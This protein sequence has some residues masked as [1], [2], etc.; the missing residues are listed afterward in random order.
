MGSISR[1]SRESQ[2]NLLNNYRV[3]ASFCGKDPTSVAN[4]SNWIECYNPSNNSWHRVTS[5]PGLMQNQVLKGF[6][7][8]SIGDILYIIGGRLCLKETTND[9]SNITDEID[10][11]VLPTVLK[12]D[13]RRDL[14]L[15]CAQMNMPRFDF[16]CTVCKNK[17]FVAGGQTTIGSAKGISSAELY[18]PGLDEWKSLP[19]MSTLRYKCAGVTWLEKILIVGGFAEKGDNGSPG[20]YIMERSSAEV[21]DCQLEKWD[22]KA[23]MWKLDIPPNQIVA[24]NERLFSSGDCLNAWKGHL[25]FYDG[26]LNMWVIVRGS[27][28]DNLSAPICTETDW[29]PLQRLFLTMAPIGTY[30]YFLAGYKVP[31]EN[32]RTRTEVH[33]FD[34]SVNGNGWRSFEPVEEEGEKELCCHS[35]V[36]KHD[37]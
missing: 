29:S 23:M 35:C 13:A 31:G 34:T 4:I 19:D 37:H 15:E 16:A 27:S 21:F 32:S 10:M 14:W 26:K 5:I 20:P 8:V 30:L 22:Y 11:K 28:L 1:L 33:V 6:S 2:Q 36:L 25:E 7:M 3:Y 9:F 24:V 17:I 18:D 12:Y